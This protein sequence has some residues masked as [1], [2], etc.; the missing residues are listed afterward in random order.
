LTVPHPSIAAPVS[1]AA[2]RAR[3]VNVCSFI[4]VLPRFS[5]PSDRLTFR[6]AAQ[7]IIA[8]PVSPTRARRIDWL[9]G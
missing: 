8:D 7:P 5:S 4:V 6:S 1:S 9:P 2:P 3:F